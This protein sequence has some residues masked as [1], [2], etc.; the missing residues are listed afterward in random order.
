MLSLDEIISRKEDLIANYDITYAKL[1]LAK[2]KYLQA[3]YNYIKARADVLNTDEEIKNS[4]KTL[5]EQI[6]AMVSIKIPETIVN[7]YR[8]T[9][10][11]IEQLEI[12]LD[13]FKAVSRELSDIIV[14]NGIKRKIMK[15]LGGGLND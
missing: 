9:A 15:D 1:I 5:K 11:E 2:S 3:N 12:A 14:I 13:H 10:F 8:S 7:E 4:K 6:E